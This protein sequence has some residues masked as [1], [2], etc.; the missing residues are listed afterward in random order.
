MSVAAATSSASAS[1]ATPDRVSGWLGGP[2]K[3]AWAKRRSG[4]RA[5]LLLLQGGG[6]RLMEGRRH[7]VDGDLRPW[8]A[9]E[10]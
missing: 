2:G 9:G 10:P 3:A 8:A 4:A 5:S 6:R 1:G 7:H